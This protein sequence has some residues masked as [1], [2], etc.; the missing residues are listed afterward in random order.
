MDQETKVAL[1]EQEIDFLKKE[2]NGI[3][4]DLK[5]KFERLEQKLDEALKGRPTWAVTLIITMLSTITTGLAVAFIAGR[6]LHG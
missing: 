1:L 4:D 2:V 6:V 5:T 3:K